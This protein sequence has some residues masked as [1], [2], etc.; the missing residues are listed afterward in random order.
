ME[1][2]RDR[3]CDTLGFVKASTM[4]IKRIARKACSQQFAAFVCSVVVW[5]L[6]SILFSRLFAA[7][8][9]NKASE[10]EEEEYQREP[11]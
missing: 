2:K 11:S 8:Q 6:T 1:R 7:H 10:N 3:T 9:S 5:L 4:Q